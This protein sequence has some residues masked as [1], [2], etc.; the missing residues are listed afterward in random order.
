MPDAG[1][2]LEAQGID[3][4]LWYRQGDTAELWNKVNKAVGPE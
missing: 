1:K 2:W 3:Y 4:V